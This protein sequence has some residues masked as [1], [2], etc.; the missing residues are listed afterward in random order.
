[1]MPRIIDLSVPVRSGTLLPPPAQRATLIT[2]YTRQ[3]TAHWQGSYLETTTHVGSHVDSPRHVIKDA[4]PIGDMPLDLVI[5]EAVLVDL[6]PV[7]SNEAIDAARLEPHGDKICAGDIVVLRTAWTDRKWDTPEFWSDSPYLTED[8]A[9]WLGERH[10]KTVVFDFFQEYVA[11]FVDFRSDDFVAHL[12]LI[13]DYGIT[14]IENATNLG[15]L[16]SPRFR[17]FAAPMKLMD[18]EGGP[19]RIFAIED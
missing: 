1:M 19:T 6:T 15:S 13:R 7:E 4:P 3:G 18:A 5:G 9:R 17:L 10:P 2:Q 16:R 8:G 12:A 11:R 14:I